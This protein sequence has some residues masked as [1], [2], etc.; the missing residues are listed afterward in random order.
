MKHYLLTMSPTNGVQALVFATSVERPSAYLSAVA[1]ELRELHVSG[2]M[3]FDF[4]MA[5]GPRSSRYFA[6]IFDGQDFGRLEEI[7]PDSRLKAVAKDFYSSH[8]DEFDTSLLTP[9]IRFAL[10]QGIDVAA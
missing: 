5:N 10:R 7:E 1:A 2:R 6:A 4:L 3:V 8:I 9:A